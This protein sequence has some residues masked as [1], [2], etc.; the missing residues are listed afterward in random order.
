MELKLYHYVHCPFCVRVRMVL[1]FLQ[2]PYESIVLPYDDEE[3][4]VRLT[5]RKMLPIILINGKAQDESLDIMTLLDVEDKLFIKNNPISSEFEDLLQKL[6]SNIHSL[7]M[8][9]WIYTAE[10]NHGS[11]EYFI[12]KK[13]LKRGPFKDLV[14]GRCKFEDPLLNDLNLISAKLKPFYQNS[15]FSYYDILLAAH[16]WGLYVVPEFQYP[17]EIHR[18][19]QTV[20]RICHFNYHEDFWR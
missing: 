11:R 12:Q 19:L 1:G 14:K 16:L 4:P 9:Y 15:T 7:A 13:Q 17:P 6:G 5:G 2:I 3:T 10:F 8:P 20:K 18:Y